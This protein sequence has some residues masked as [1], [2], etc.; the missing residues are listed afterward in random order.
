MLW[1]G[2]LCASNMLFSKSRC[3]RG[4]YIWSVWGRP[5]DG[6]AKLGFVAA[7]ALDHPI[8]RLLLCVV[9]LDLR[10]CCCFLQPHGLVKNLLGICWGF[11]ALEEV[12]PWG[13]DHVALGLSACGSRGQAARLSITCEGLGGD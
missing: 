9:P 7:P 1:Q 8:N 5:W 2:M 6:G 10:S 11:V 12:K 4:R 13:F 3:L